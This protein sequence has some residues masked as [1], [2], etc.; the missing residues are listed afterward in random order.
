MSSNILHQKDGITAVPPSLLTPLLIGVNHS[1]GYNGA[2]GQTYR[3]INAFQY[4]SS[5]KTSRLLLVPVCTNHWLSITKTLSLLF[6]IEAM[7]YT[8][9][10]SR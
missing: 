9:Q 10:A 5:E 2:T 8:V 4:A 3:L 1:L 6:L 7:P